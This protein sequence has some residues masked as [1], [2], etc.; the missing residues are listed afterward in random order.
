MK[1]SGQLHAAVVLPNGT[2]LIKDEMGG[3]CSTRGRDEKCVSHFGRIL[4]RRDLRC[5]W[6][7]NIRI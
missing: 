6:V 2:D 1:V 5:R 4:L 7:D 3:A